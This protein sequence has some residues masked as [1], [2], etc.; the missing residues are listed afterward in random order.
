MD[1]RVGPWLIRPDLNQAV[2]NSRSLHLTPKSMEVLVC[3]ARHEGGVVSKDVLFQEV[4]TGT[5]VTDDALT[6]CIGE[7]RRTLD[8]AGPEPPVI[9]TIARRGYRMAVPITWETE[10]RTVDAGAAAPWWKR[11]WALAA[12]GVVVMLLVVLAVWAALGI[13]REPP[14]IRSI[15]V[16][17]LANDSGDS[18]QEFFADGMTEELITELAQ[19]DAWKVISRT[20]VMRY[21]GTKKPL[22]EIARDLA[23]DAVVEG[24]VLR[25]GSQVRITAQL[26]HADTD[27]HVW[28]GSF[29]REMSDVL[30]L[31]REIA[32]SIA[33]ELR[34]TL[35]T[36]EPRHPSRSRKV[37]PEAYEAYLKGW[38][39]YNR[40][41]FAKAASFFEQATLKDPGFALA[42]IMLAEAD[43]ME[44]FTQDL[45]MSARAMTAM[46]T[47][48]TLDGTLAEVHAAIAD[49]QFY[50]DW[51]WKAGEEGFRRAVEID[52]GSIDSAFHYAL[53]LHALAKW[54]AAL[55]EYRR[56]LELDPV[57]PRLNGQ[58]LGCLV[59]AHRDQEAMDQ[60]RKTIELD[61]NNAFAW[62][63]VGQLYNRQGRVGEALGAWLKRD[64]LGGYSAEQ[65]KALESA[66]RAGGLRGYWAKHVEILKEKS[67]RTRV[68]PREVA[69]AYLLAG[70][71]DKA[72]EMLETAYQQRAPRLTWI[73]ANA[74][75]DPLRSDPR[76]Q[77]LLRRMRFPE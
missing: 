2:R 18:D 45:P 75:W 26:I 54:E 68:P 21:K 14:P 50:T 22:P 67:K 56:S 11:R 43:G 63:R 36:P 3:L 41:Q 44:A 66:A 27:R 53:A 15:A 38:H 55:R 16:L 64:S 35:G 47:A 12:G 23:V 6:K 20:S 74:V 39:F 57:S 70:E 31:Q 25:S 42:F 33:A 9:E 48:R 62:W 71:N 24:A 8:T 58:F 46:E 69:L 73:R 59:D 34:V 52:R 37:V 40:Y 5:Y 10:E 65:L 76:F 60:F 72:M 13:W 19:L 32:R 1:F 49:V 28:A 77:A 4:W 61:P 7:L 17:P 51:N 30:S 29:E